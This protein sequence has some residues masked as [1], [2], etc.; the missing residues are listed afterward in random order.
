MI[1]HDETMMLKTPFHSR[2][3]AACEINMWE[4]WNNRKHFIFKGK[5]LQEPNEVK[6]FRDCIYGCDH[7][8]KDRTPCKRPAIR[9]PNKTEP[10]NKIIIGRRSERSCA[11]CISTSWG[12]KKEK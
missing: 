10:R 11:K 9:T 5:I 1:P 3:E 4:D 6:E 12:F 8:L 7:V 2:I